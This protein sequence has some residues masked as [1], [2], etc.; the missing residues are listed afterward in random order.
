[1]F[2]TTCSV[3]KIRND[4][5][6]IEIV[7]PEGTMKICNDK[8]KF[9]KITRSE[10]SLSEDRPTVSNSSSSREGRPWSKE[11]I[12]ENSKCLSFGKVLLLLGLLP[13][14]LIP[15]CYNLHAAFER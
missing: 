13:W 4:V 7:T 14:N 3:N 12:F 15:M 1:M 11:P 8:E 6:L 10:N 9:E 2:E 5:S